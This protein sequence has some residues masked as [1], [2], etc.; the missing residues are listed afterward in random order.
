MARNSGFGSII[1]GIAWIWFISTIL[2]DYLKIGFW[3]ALG[4]VVGIHILIVAVVIG[5][6]SATR[7]IR[8]RA[9]CAHGV[10]RGKQGGCESCLDDEKREQ[11]EWEIRRLEQQAKKDIQKKANA[12]RES[13]LKALRSR[14]LSRAE[15]YFEMS[16][17]QFENAIA[18]VFRQ[19]GYEVKQTPYSNDRGRDAIAWKDGQKFLIECKRYGKD[20]AIGRRELQIFFAAMKE[21]AVEAGFYV[22]TGRFARTAYEY[23]AL[24]HIELIDREKFSTLIN[25]AFPIKE[26]ISTVSIMC[27][28]C[29]EVGSFPIGE[30]CVSGQCANGHSITNDI[31]IAVIRSSSFLSG[32]ICDRCGSQMRIVNGRRGKFWGCSKYPKCKFIKRHQ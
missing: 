24:N 6:E 4:I 25:T 15:L 7:A 18:E 21:E 32:V 5:W 3:S 27:H 16:P 2:R 20:K 1:T 26:N 22:N 28:D 19:L 30:E 13:E 10:K 29:G 17:Q 9:R 31:T 11:S 23:A 12:L 8:R 14:W